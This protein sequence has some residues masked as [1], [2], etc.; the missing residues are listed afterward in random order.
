[1]NCL[2]GKYGERFLCKSKFELLEITAIVV[3]ISFYRNRFK[4][5]SVKP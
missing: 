2:V 3:E 5:I 1:M 4:I